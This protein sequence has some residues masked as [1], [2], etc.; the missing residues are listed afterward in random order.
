MMD[1]LVK[2]VEYGSSHVVNAREIH[3]ALN[4]RRDFSNLDQ[5]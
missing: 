3:A 5:G 2:V 4:V 1:E